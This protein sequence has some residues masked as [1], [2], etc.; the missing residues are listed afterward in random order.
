IRGPGHNIRHGHDD[1]V[2][3]RDGNKSA[4]SHVVFAEGDAGDT[5]FEAIAADCACSKVE[6]ALDNG[7]GYVDGGGSSVDIGLGLNDSGEL[8]AS[9]NYHRGGGG[10]DRD[11]LDVG[12]DIGA[13]DRDGLRDTRG[14]RGAAAATLGRISADV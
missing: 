13:G 14:W 6:I 3:L 1:C 8:G 12:D 9:Y 5:G 7:G 4:G 11:R 2:S 10:L